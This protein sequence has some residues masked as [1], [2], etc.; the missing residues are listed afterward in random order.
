MSDPVPGRR[1][2]QVD[3]WGPLGVRTTVVYFDHAVDPALTERLRSVIA[4]ALAL[5]PLGDSDARL[6]LAAEVAKRMA[7]EEA[8]ERECERRSVTAVTAPGAQRLCGCG[9]SIDGRGDKRHCSDRC[10]QRAHRSAQAEPLV[11]SGP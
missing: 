10:R 2:L 4:D 9:E 6:L 7:D 3:E 8:Y 11:T 5:V 1:R